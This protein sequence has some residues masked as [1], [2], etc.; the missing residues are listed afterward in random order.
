MKPRT[1][2]A[3]SAFTLIELL[4]V[5]AIIAILAAMLLP[6]LARAK[7]AA[8]KTSCLNKLKQLGLAETIYAQDNN[9]YIP[10]ESSIANSKLEPWNNVANPPTFTN[11]WYNSLPTLVNLNPA[12]F[13]APNATSQAAFYNSSLL[14]HCSSAQFTS[15]STPLAGDAYFS[16]A[17]NSQLN[18]GTTTIRTDVIKLPSSTVI[19]LDNL[20]AGDPVVDSNQKTTNLGQ[21]GSYAD[22]FGA[23]HNGSGN[24]AFVDGHAASF[25]GNKVVQTKPGVAHSPE[26][27]AIYPQTEIVWT[28]DPS[29]VP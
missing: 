2:P 13:Y 11:V 9:D 27:G 15:V 25:V 1:N 20:L 6:A 17:M 28:P 16:I 22:R 5:I 14:F 23:R 18:T 4:V 21:P 3:S 12:S 26:G 29:S 10:H 7:G 24:L 19:F 8:Q